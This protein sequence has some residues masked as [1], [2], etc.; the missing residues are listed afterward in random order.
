MKH[1]RI[2]TRGSALALWQSRHVASILSRTL[3]GMRQAGRYLPEYRELRSKA[4]FLTVC[5]TP[6]LAAEVTLQP[7]RRFQFDAAIMC[8]CG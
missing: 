1:L 3:P 2:G 5:R 4:D 8:C 6:E 7:L